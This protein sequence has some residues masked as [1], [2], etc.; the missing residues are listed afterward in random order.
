MYELQEVFSRIYHG[1]LGTYAPLRQ[2][3]GGSEL[4]EDTFNYLTT[5]VRRWTVRV[6]TPCG[7]SPQH[8]AFDT[9]QCSFNGRQQR[10]LAPAMFDMNNQRARQR[11]MSK[12][13][14]HVFLD[15]PSS[16]VMT[17]EFSF[18]DPSRGVRVTYLAPAIDMPNHSGT[19]LPGCVWRLLHMCRACCIWG[20]CCAL[21]QSAGDLHGVQVRCVQIRCEERMHVC[22]P[23]A[24][25]TLTHSALL[26]RHAQ[27]KAETHGTRRLYVDHNRRAAQHKAGRRGACLG[28]A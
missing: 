7:R 26:F 14:F 28:P 15:S 18:P 12:S 11:R 4:D 8:R 17:R 1:R 2:T 24:V 23:V 6:G 3:I 20:S 25:A 16:Q 10:L 13:V 19:K 21:R 22:L 5:L 27:R 9:V